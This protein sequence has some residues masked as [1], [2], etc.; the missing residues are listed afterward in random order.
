[1]ELTRPGATGRQTIQKYGAGGFRISGVDFIG[2]VIVMP[3]KAVAWPATRIEDLKASD[4]AALTAEGGFDVC[5]LG[6]GVRMEQ[7]PEPLRA[8][9]MEAGLKLDPM[10][11]GAACRTFNMLMGEERHAAAALIAI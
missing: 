7:V 11:T 6:C 8:A 1:L 9:L 2:S 3:G 10:G 5:L 4:F